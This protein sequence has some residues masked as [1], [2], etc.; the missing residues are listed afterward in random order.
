[1]VVAA[2]VG[3]T[4][5]ATFRVREVKVLRPNRGGS[6][7]IRS[8]PF[9]TPSTLNRN[10]DVTG[11]DRVWLT[12]STCIATSEGR[13]DFVAVVESFVLTN[14]DKRGESSHDIPKR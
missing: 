6:I 3:S 7:F 14:S 5:D 9:L 13:L 2:S 10:F 4:G 8:S 1:M 11:P 12:P